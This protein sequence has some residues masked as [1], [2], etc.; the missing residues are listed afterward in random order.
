MHSFLHH[1]VDEVF[2]VA[3]KD[4]AEQEQASGFLVGGLAH[5]QSAHFVPDQ[6][7]SPCVHDYFGEDS[8]GSCLLDH[9]RV[10][11]GD[12]L[13][14]N[15]EG[16]AECEELEVN[17][18][19]LDVEFSEVLDVVS[20]HLLDEIR[21]YE[22]VLKRVLVILQEVFV[23][24]QSDLVFL[25]IGVDEDHALDLVVNAVPDEVVL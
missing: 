3:L 11:D 2:L 14:S 4:D 9:S 25:D 1:S 16:L 5:P 6:E 12:G 23:C 15:R 20:E 13:Q 21:F 8:W 17:L 18:G 19:E 22:L 7:M 24:V 10:E